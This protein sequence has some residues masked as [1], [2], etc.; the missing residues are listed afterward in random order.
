MQLLQELIQINRDNELEALFEELGNLGKLGLGPM[1]NA[2][3]QSYAAYS[4]GREGMRK[5]TGEE[6]KK[7]DQQMIGIGKDSEAVEAGTPKNW[8]TVK[9]FYKQHS[10]DK[11]LAA[12]I[13]VDDKPVALMIASE[14]D[15]TSVNDKIVLAWDF[16]KVAPD[17]EE[18]KKLVAGLNTSDG[19]RWRT[20]VVGTTAK[21]GVSARKETEK[22]RDYDFQK[23]DYVEKFTTKKYTGFTQTVREVAPFVNGIC[24]AFGNRV[25]VTLILA[26]KTRMAKRQE[27]SRNRPID[28]K[29][30]KL[31]SDELSVRLAKYKNSKIET[32]EDAMDFVKKVFG[33]G[34]K[35]IKFAGRSYSAV[36]EKEYVGSTSDKR[37]EGGHNYFY[38]GTMQDLMTGKKVTMKFDADRQERDYN[39]LYLTVKMVKGTLVPVEMRYNDKMDG[40]YGSSKTVKLD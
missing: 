19:R 17:E 7:F 34:L 4:K 23:K 2:F 15:M 24:N 13:K 36:P 6:G 32:A 30:I 9:K 14:Y 37:R 21:P 1:V 40:S 3:K 22:E 11:P 38:N 31:F 35:K 16:S 29:D 5:R 28:P 10:E 8:N 12:V 27:R 25:S 18:A 39:T 33:G 26:D 20:E